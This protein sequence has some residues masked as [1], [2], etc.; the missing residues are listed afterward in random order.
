MPLEKLVKDIMRPLNQYPSIEENER[1][2]RALQLMKGAID[3]KKLP[4]LIVVGDG[5]DDKKVIKGFVTPSEIVFGMADHFLKGAK[6]IGPIFW[7]G[8]LKS[9][10]TE[11]F[12]KRVSEIMSPI[13]TCINGTEKLMEAIFLLNKYQVGF[14]P[15]VRCEEVTGII[16]LDDILKAIVEMA[17]GLAASSDEGAQGRS[18]KRK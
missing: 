3:E 9:E 1:V 4:H 15:V 7:E 14:L 12:Q 5:D 16:H 6:S 10:C 18:K 13:K 17:G 8:Q 2:E 11:A